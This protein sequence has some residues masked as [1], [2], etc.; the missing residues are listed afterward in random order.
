M[1]PTVWRKGKSIQIH[2]DPEMTWEGLLALERE[3][4]AA[5]WFMD[6]SAPRIVSGVGGI[7][8]NTDNEWKDILKTIK[9]NSGKN[10]TI[11]V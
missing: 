5:G 10:N 3:L 2:D 6:L 7:G 8:R 1:R 4:N 9:K 11:H